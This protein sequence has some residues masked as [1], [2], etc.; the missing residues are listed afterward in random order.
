MLAGIAGAAPTPDSLRAR[1]DAVVKS[2]QAND[3]ATALASLPPL[4]SDI[5]ASADRAL[6]AEA[7]I[8]QASAQ[9]RSAQYPNAFA[10]YQRSLEASRAAGSRSFEARSIWGMAQVRKNQGNYPEAVRLNSEARAAYVA[11]EDAK[12]EMRTWLLEGA[13]LDLTGEHRAALQ[14]YLRARSL[15][16]DGEANYGLVHGEMGI[17]HQRL[18]EFEQ[19]RAMFLKALEVHRSTGYQY[20]QANNLYQLGTLSAV[21][22]DYDRAVALCE[23]ALAITR[24]I[25]ERRGEVYV[26]GTLANLWWQREDDVRASTAF[27]RQ[28]ALAQQ[29]GIS[30]PQVTALD[31][32]GTIALA[33]G[34]NELAR[35]RFGR[36]L[37]IERASHGGEEAA[38]L[39]ALSGVELRDSKVGTARE[40]AGR[41]LE[42]A[43]ADEDPETEWQARLALSRAARAARDPQAA[44][45][46]LRAGVAVVNSIRGRVLTDTGKVGYLDARQDLFHELAGTLMQESRAMEALEVAEA[47]RG[48]AFSDLLASR[49]RQSDGGDRPLLAQLRESEA[50]LRAQVGTSTSDTELHA[51][52]TRT[53]AAMEAKIDAQ[54]SALRDERRELA[55]LVVAEPVSAAEIRATAARLRATIIEY[56]VAPDR[57]F[58][59]VVQPS[60]GLFATSVQVDRAR[61]RDTVR[62]LHRQF[63][64]LDAAALRNPAPARRLLHQLHRWTVEPVA[65]R[66]PRDSG[67]LL[68]VVPHDALL[69]VPFAALEDDK[70]R[71][72]LATHTI[73]SAPSIATLRY[74]ADKRRRANGLDG[75]RL[76][77]LA[78]PIS[79]PDAA[80]ESLPGA[81]TEVRGI[82]QRFAADRRLALEGAEASEKN[83]KQLSGGQTILHFAVHGLVRDDRP[84]DS[85]LLL[86]PGGGEDGWLRVSELF[87]FE[88]E[89]DLVVLSGCSTGAG[90]LSGDG[91]L[92]LGRAFIYAGTP[93]VV[94]SQ[95]DVS[96]VSTAYLMERFYAELLAGRPKARALRAAQIAAQKRFPHPALWAAFVLVG[97]AQ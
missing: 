77:A 73:A 6:L 1:L 34:D 54:L 46:H 84:W 25:G 86:S 12:G 20:G 3:V 47:A 44:L 89:A 40:M 9:F 21:L 68:F 42:M 87:D 55:S 58:I 85:A 26:L 72:L 50:R 52:L 36:A 30:Q 2:L 23:E 81:R 66:L 57:L 14:S 96:D 74:T 4:I 67:A 79:P 56:L 59:W 11:I 51:E 71:T 10:S 49:A 18:G 35:Q 64:E 33:R 38:L 88:L 90:K 45:T 22:G 28:L 31:G 76:L 16:K 94:V 15:I 93:T 70:G 7:L 41:A 32:L 29:L 27:E 63:N 8:Q 92:G 5:S 19:A 37:E 39:V 69:M 13:L 95:W 75:A 65:D 48:R 91:I 83:A 78:D 53:R 60:G 97:E 43:R 80:M 61:L 82:S 17:S 62:E 24:T